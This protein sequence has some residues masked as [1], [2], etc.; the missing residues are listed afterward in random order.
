MADRVR[1]QQKATS[2]VGTRT[3]VLLNGHP[4]HLYIYRGGVQ[5]ASSQVM[6]MW[7][8]TA[9]RIAPFSR[10]SRLPGW[11]VPGRS[12]ALSLADGAGYAT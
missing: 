7:T 8:Y 4:V 10:P 2:H 1:R 9:V 12:V 6:M 11:G 5:P 3:A